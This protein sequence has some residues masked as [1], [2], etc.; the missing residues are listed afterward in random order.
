VSFER[1]IVQAVAGGPA[2]LP[3]QPHNWKT[4]LLGR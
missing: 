1:E 4:L 3:D 2:A